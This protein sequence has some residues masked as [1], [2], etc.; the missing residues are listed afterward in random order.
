LKDL[1]KSISPQS[2]KPKVKVM[3]RVSFSVLI[4][5]LSLLLFMNCEKNTLGPIHYVKPEGRLVFTDGD[6]LYTVDP[7][8]RNLSLLRSN[9]ICGYLKWSPD[10]KYIACGG[11]GTGLE[12]ISRSG[13]TIIEFTEY[14]IGLYMHTTGFDWSADSQRLIFTVFQDYIGS[15]IY[16]YHLGETKPRKVLTT[17]MY[18]M[19]GDP[20]LS[21]DGKTIA[22][23]FHENGTHFGICLISENDS[24]AHLTVDGTSGFNERMDLDWLDNEHLVY[25]ISKKGIFVVDTAGTNLQRVCGL[26]SDYYSYHLKLSADGQ[27]AVL[28]DREHARSLDTQ[29]W[30]GKSYDDIESLHDMAVSPDHSV[31]ALACGEG[32]SLF[33][34]D[35]VDPQCIFESKCVAVDWTKVEGGGVK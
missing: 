4:A 16:D 30:S 35:G 9:V 20:A 8:G 7:D 27:K 21:T 5:L 13:E 31:Y 14:T 34:F 17:R 15:N 25:K 11:P 3:K 6:N 28:F 22:F 33:W 32:L 19:F 18:I 10:G 1:F 24:L 12:I 2:S 26:S 23:V 29:T